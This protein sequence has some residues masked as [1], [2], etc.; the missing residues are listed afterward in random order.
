LNV[1][2]ILFGAWQ[3]AK[4]VLD[5]LDKTVLQSRSSNT[6]TITVFIIC[7][8]T[9]A[10]SSSYVAMAGLAYSGNAVGRVNSY[11]EPG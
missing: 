6:R 7:I 11:V 9:T 3:T 8:N 4:A 1:A 10:R 5:M 2:I